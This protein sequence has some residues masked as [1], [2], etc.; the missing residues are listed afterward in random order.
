METS[1]AENVTPS[2]TICCFG[3]FEDA[4]NNNNN[5]KHRSTAAAIMTMTSPSIPVAKATVAAEP[6][7]EWAA[8]G[9]YGI[10]RNPDF[11]MY[12]GVRTFRRTLLERGFKHDM[13]TYLMGQPL[14][15]VSDRMAELGITSLLEPP[16]HVTIELDLETHEYIVYRRDLMKTELVPAMSSRFFPADP[17]CVGSCSKENVAPK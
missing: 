13:I 12:M 3:S 16:T 7:D 6:P 10:D 2:L 11:S 15:S 4:H 14:S 8:D 9:R 17:T 1:E 5:N